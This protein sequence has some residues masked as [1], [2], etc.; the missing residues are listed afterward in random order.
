MYKA[1][2]G[3]RR[4]RNGAPTPDWALL[5]PSHHGPVRAEPFDIAQD[6]LHAFGYGVEAS[7]SV[8]VT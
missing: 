5:H 1:E 3:M 2:S 7:R 4:K 6:K 8:V